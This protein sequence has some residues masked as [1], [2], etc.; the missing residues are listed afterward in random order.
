[1]AGARAY[2]S[3]LVPIA[4]GAV[5]R[6]R[7][8]VARPDPPPPLVGERRLIGGRYLPE[9]VLGSGGDGVALLARDTLT[10]AV[11]TLKM[12]ARGDLVVY[13]RLVS[14]GVPWPATL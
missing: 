4:R 14:L 8:M 11:V 7:E 2:L 1:A 12:P 6:E 9:A 5:A 3:A 13:E 10:G